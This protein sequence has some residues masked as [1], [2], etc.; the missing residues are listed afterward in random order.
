MSPELQKQFLQTMVR[1]SSKLPPEAS[2]ATKFDSKFNWYYDKAVQECKILYCQKGTDDVY[3]LFISKD[4]RSITPMK[5]GV[6]VKVKLGTSDTFNYYNEVF[7]MWKMPEDTLVKR[8]KFLFTR[9]VKGE[10][11][12]LYY[13]KFQQDRFVEFP[14]D[15]FYFDTTAWRWKDRELDSLKIN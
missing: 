5:E 14:D 7:R 10:D 11:L 12:S 2:Q 9:M 13:S 1:Y 3:S 15:R 4:A 8:G 6:A